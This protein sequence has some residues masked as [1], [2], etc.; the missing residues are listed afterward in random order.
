MRPRRRCSG[1]GPSTPT[2]GAAARS[3]SAR[4]VGRARATGLGALAVEHHPHQVAEGRQRV[5]AAALHLAGEELLDR[6]ARAELHR[7]R[8]G[9]VGL[10]DDPGGLAAAPGAARRAGRSARR[11]APPSGSPAC[12]RG[13]SA[14]TA[15]AT[16]TSGRSW[17]LATIW[18]PSR[19]AAP[20]PRE[21]GQ[22][23]RDGAR[24]PTRSS[25]PSAR[26]APTGTRR[27]QGRLD[28][29]RPRALAHDVGA[30]AARADARA[31]G[32]SWPQWWQASRRGPLVLHQGDVAVG[33]AGDP[34]ALAAEGHQREAAP[35]GEHDRLL[36]AQGGRVQR[37]PRA[38]ARP[39]P[40]PW[41]RM[42]TIS[43]AGRREP[44]A[45]AGSARRGSAF[46]A[47]GRGVALP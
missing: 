15:P 12:C 13:A 14:S 44:S 38:G 11:P 29:L 30:R 1:E 39:G 31:R 47:S 41:V 6:V 35:A 36:A 7:P 20:G 43:T 42:S 3:A 10:H 24:A 21:L 5:R 26:S 22:Q 19:I 33:A 40:A 17:P 16:V 4:S 9:L 8:R 23:A 25:R 28:P 34:A 45:R 46:Q 37:A 32:S 27:A 18:V 2:S